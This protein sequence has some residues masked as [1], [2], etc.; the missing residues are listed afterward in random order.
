MTPT[1][2]HI[3]FVCSGSKCRK[4]GSKDLCKAI[5]KHLRHTALP[6]T[7]ELIQMHCTDRCDDAPVVCLQPANQWLKKAEPEPLARWLH[8]YFPEAR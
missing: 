7:V 3:V 5:R 4:K 2:A 1:T 6:G 8:S